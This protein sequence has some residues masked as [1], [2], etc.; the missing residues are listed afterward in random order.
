MATTTELSD[1]EAQLQRV[2]AHI[3]EL[4]RTGRLE[5]AR[6]VGFVR[7][8][9]EQALARRP[10]APRSDL[11]TTGQAALV[12][13][14]SDQTVRNWAAAGRIPAVTRGVRLMIPRAAIL[15][16]I[17]RSRVRPTR[18]AAPDEEARTTWRRE[19]LGSLPRE[20]M[21]RLDGLHDRLEEGHELSPEEAAEMADLE[22]TMANAAARRLQTIIRH[23]RAAP[24]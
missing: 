17:E 6:A 23:G 14:I 8:L 19:L 9:A 5:D 13:G 1:A 22:R 24:T 12:L 15:E 11:L 18:Q 20:L 2:Q 7:D 10:A 4:R 3:E 21:A 16:E